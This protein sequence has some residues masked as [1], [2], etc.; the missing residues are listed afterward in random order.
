MS[1]KPAKKKASPQKK[2]KVLSLI[3]EDNR[4]SRRERRRQKQQEEE[5]AKV[6]PVEKAKEEALNL[7]DD[8]PAEKKVVSEP[9]G[10]SEAEEVEA[11]PDPEKTVSLKPPI[12][13][14]DL[15]EAME[16]KPFK[17]IQDLMEFDVFA[18]PTHSVEPEIAAKICDKHGFYFEREKREKGGGVHKTEVNIVEPELPDTEKEDDLEYRAPIIT[19][20]GH[21]DHG[22]TSLLDKIR[23]SRVTAGEAGGITQHVGAYSV[24]HQG[25]HITFLDT[26]GHA[27]FSSMRARGADVTDVVVLVIAADD[28]IMPQTKEAIDHAKAAKVEI[29]V[30]INKCDL[31]TAN[32]DR[33]M[34]QLA[35]NDLSPTSYGGSTECVQV[36]AQ[37]GEGISELLETLLLQAEVLELRAN[38][39]GTARA[40][41]IEAKTE[42]GK[43][44]TATAI[45]QTGTL[46]VGMPFICGSFAGK[47]KG[48]LNDRGERVKE[49]G[50]AMPVE[51]LGFNGIPNVGDDVVEMES[52]RDAKKLGDERQEEARKEKLLAPQRSRMEDM[53]AT[54][55]AGEQKTMKMVLKTDVQG[56]A[57]AIAEALGE[58]ESEKIQL[59]IIHKAAGAIT[60]SDI[61]LA[62][63][64]DAIVIGFNTKTE[65]KALAAAK[66]EGVQIKLFSI[67]YEL[68][69]QVKDAMLG[70]LEPETREKIIGHAEVKQIFKIRRGRVAGCIV[71]DGKVTRDA[72]ARVL[73]DRQPV[74][75]GGVHTLRRFQD[76]VDE[77]KMGVECGIRLGDYNEY[78]EG[79]IIETYLLEKIEQ[80]L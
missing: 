38:P 8:E 40:T 37:T 49:A 21:V 58:I 19:F 24:E 78:E 69:D 7:L 70:M 13:V 75:D 1:S 29:V 55:K 67:V 5:E 72:R 54:I 50:P 33:V 74:Y 79:D 77:V 41:V 3:D 34:A 10:A 30:A 20:M 53:L 22:K 61:L 26:P 71:Q 39:A 2:K 31:A 60:E 32:P 12:I 42:A 11:G 76:D 47:I 16:L 6:S 35:E 43:G 65:N 27:V 45:V 15:A 28:G 44:P 52:E 4:P 56:T 62:S 57:Q 80:T 48:L 51:L 23:E 64:S 17:I 18:T 59:D 68:I 25:K 36:S 14:K 46:K 9:A 63:A 66:R 73:R